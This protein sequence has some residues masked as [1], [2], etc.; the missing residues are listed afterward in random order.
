MLVSP[1]SYPADYVWWITVFTLVAH[2]RFLLLSPENKGVYVGVCCISACVACAFQREREGR[3]DSFSQ[4]PL[5]RTCTNW[6]WVT[7]LQG[8]RKQIEVNH[9]CRS[10]MMTLMELALKC[11]SVYFSMRPSVCVAAK[12]VLQVIWCIVIHLPLHHHHHSPSPIHSEKTE[13]SRKRWNIDKK[14][15]S[16]CHLF[17][18]P[19]IYVFFLFFFTSSICKWRQL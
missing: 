7:C 14:K 9:F 5:L 12:G 4:P 13:L 2:S 16:R 15:Y 1:I 6:I 3:A 8:I 17:T 10:A 18:S 19:V 11:C